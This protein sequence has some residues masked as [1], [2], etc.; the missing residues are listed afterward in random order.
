[1]RY[2]RI[3]N[4]LHRLYTYDK[5][6]ATAAMLLSG[7]S[8]YKDILEKNVDL[9]KS[10]NSELMEENTLTNPHSALFARADITHDCKVNHLHYLTTFINIIC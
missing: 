8:I 7:T 2:L 5:S 6:A 10:F 1:M 9:D 3:H 4:I